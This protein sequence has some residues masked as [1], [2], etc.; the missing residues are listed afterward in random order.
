M[1]RRSLFQSGNPVMRESI[2]RTASQEVLDAGMT[3]AASER[4]T[5]RGAITKSFILAAILLFTAA[6]GFSMPSP[7]MVWGGAIGGFVLVM[8]MSFRPQ[9][10]PTLAPVYAALEGL[11][12]GAVSF[13]YAAQFAGIVF[14]AFSLTIAALFAMLFIYQSG[15]IKVTGRF[16]TM[17]VMATG[18]IALVYILS[19]V[20]NLF[21]ITMPYLHQGGPIGLGISAVILAIACLNL[22]LD[23][24]NFK[25]GEQYGAPAY[26]EWFSAMG[27]MVTL[28]W[29]Y[30][31]ILRLLSRLRE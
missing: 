19:L 26:M 31:E 29:I 2:Y 8:V 15:I 13:V 25:M 22:L 30:L 9:L 18:A 23:F 11:F 6:I 17:L 1:A 14:Q 16:R 5:V 12:L 24:D 21:G 3:S 4:M 20:L 27:L 28:V 10:S 7:L